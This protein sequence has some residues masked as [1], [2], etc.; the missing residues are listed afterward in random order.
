MIAYANRLR[1]GWGQV[2]GQAA[3]TAVSVGLSY[4]A[5]V[6]SSLLTDFI[7]ARLPQEPTTLVILALMAGFSLGIWI[8]VEIIKALMDRGLLSA[9][10]GNLAAPAILGMGIA[11][12]PAL[13][14]SQYCL[15][16]LNGI[17][18]AQRL[19]EL[20]AAL[21]PVISGVVGSAKLKKA[22]YQ[23]WLSLETLIENLVVVNRRVDEGMIQNNFIGQYGRLVPIPQ[24]TLRSFMENFVAR[25]DYRRILP[26]SLL[27]E[28]DRSDPQNW[29]LVWVDNPPGAHSPK[30]LPHAAR[31]HIPDEFEQW[32]LLV[33]W[34]LDDDETSY[35]RLRNEA[36]TKAGLF[37]LVWDRIEFELA[38]VRK[39]ITEAKG[40]SSEVHRRLMELED[41]L[42][43][44]PDKSAA[45]AAETGDPVQREQDHI[46]SQWLNNELETA[47]YRLLSLARHNKLTQTTWNMIEAQLDNYPRLKLEESD[48]KQLQALKQRR[49]D[50]IKKGFKPE[51]YQTWKKVEEKRL[52]LIE[53]GVN[54][55]LLQAGQG[56]VA[57]AKGL[58]QAGLSSQEVEQWTE[59]VDQEN[60]LLKGGFNLQQAQTWKA[61]EV[62]WEK[63]LEKVYGAEMDEFDAE[64]FLKLEQLVHY[65]KNP[66]YL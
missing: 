48:A 25:R 23:N 34:L 65:K 62:N 55:Q 20:V 44:K 30:P 24:D 7:S 28:L 4:L 51:E 59:L 21:L 11:Y 9:D 17:L 27:V 57:V 49:A 15:D 50:L 45:K 2:A 32:Q 1:R 52:A 19:V 53:K 63:L 40:A 22:S 14:L 3:W 60:I 43:L 41:I 54:P 16:F 58:Y 10:A 47:Y 56:S 39:Q 13:L 6:N 36:L 38:R 37:P 42:R 12:P 26:D 64:M 35:Y 46:L 5:G 29:A 61:D 66:D 8:L 18:S 31:R 33:K